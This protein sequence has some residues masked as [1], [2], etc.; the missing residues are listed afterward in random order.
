MDINKTLSKLRTHVPQSVIA[1]LPFVI[2]KYDINTNLRLAHFLSQ[3][4]H[5]S[6]NFTQKTE[7]LNYS[8]KR[9]TEV[10]KKYFPTITN[11]T[12]YQRNPEKIANLVYANR[13]GNGSESSGDGF[14]YRGRGY[15]QLTGKEMYIKFGRSIDVDLVK[16]PELVATKYPLASAAWFF[17]TR[18]VNE[19]ADKGATNEVITLVT[20][21]VN[22]GRNGLDDR[23]KKFNLYHKILTS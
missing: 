3:C 20:L 5:E 6:G 7:N 2:E 16:T 4:A 18:N 9:L 1:E 23:I 19:I 13:M 12:P 22:G 10:F 11:A 14:R 17:D 8:A 21:R 15:I